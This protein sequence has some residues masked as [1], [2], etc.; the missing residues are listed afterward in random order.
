MITKH[1]LSYAFKKIALISGFVACFHTLHAQTVIGP[2]NP[3]N[4]LA[5]ASDPHINCDMLMLW[6]GTLQAIAWDAGSS[7]MVDVRDFTGAVAT[8]SI[9]NALTP[10]VAL[11]N[12]VAPSG[13][14]EHTVAVVYYDPVTGGARLNTYSIPDAGSGSLTPTLDYSY[15]LTS[16]A[17]AFPHIDMFADP[18]FQIFGM[19]SLHQCVIS[20]E[21]VNAPSPNEVYTI[22]GE[23]D[24][25][26]A[27]SAP[28]LV[29]TASSPFSEIGADVAASYNVNTGEQLA[30][31]VVSH[32][33]VDF[34]EVNC[35]INALTAYAPLYPATSYFPHIE[36]MGLYD[37]GVS[38]FPWTVLAP[39]YSSTVDIYMFNDLTG[40]G[41][42]C[43]AL[44]GTN[45]DKRAVAVAAGLGQPY[46]GYCNDNYVIGWYDAANGYLTQS[47]DYPSGTINMPSDFYQANTNSIGN[48]G[49]KMPFA[50]S[51]TSNDGTLLLTVWYSGTPGNQI[52]YKLTND[53]LSY[54]PTA[55]ARFPQAE[56]PFLYPNPARSSF[57][58]EARQGTRLE[59][60]TVYNMLGQVVYT[61]PANGA[62]QVN[63]SGYAAG[64]YQVAIDTD[65]GRTMQKLQVLP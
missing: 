42:N 53:N 21:Q 8:I 48:I 26:A 23:L 36:A 20:Y 28:L 44:F 64:T 30:Y 15:T 43:T 39:V 63:T 45:S 12:R 38:A 24:N 62:A 19:P 9:P 40:G 29:A 22:Y 58:V 25:P 46:G 65:K 10:D 51:S 18:N 32:S 56:G 17:G 6:G 34:A 52:F 1:H 49:G 27:F 7:V 3:D 50:M 11:G 14:I 61:A 35:T 4:F 13:V 33:Q 37:P 16:S 59:R 57:S 54:K 47:I 41:V 2:S 31:F 60:I 55:I 5:P